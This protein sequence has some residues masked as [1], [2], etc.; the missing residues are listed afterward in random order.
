MVNLN[1]NVK[2]KSKCLE[3]MQIAHTYQRAQTRPHL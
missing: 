1:L 2:S 3:N